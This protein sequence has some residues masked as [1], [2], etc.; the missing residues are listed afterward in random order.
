MCNSPIEE[1]QWIST[2]HIS[3]FLLFNLKTG[4]LDQLIYRAIEIASPSN[5]F[6]GRVQ[7]VLDKA[8]GSIRGET[9][10]DKDE[11]SI[12]FQYPVSTS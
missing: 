7:A 4:L 2:V 8:D 1:T 9:M 3:I 5:A 10:L 12:R 6:P 11:F